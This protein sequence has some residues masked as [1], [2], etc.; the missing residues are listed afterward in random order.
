M[1]SGGPLFLE[2]NRILIGISRSTFNRVGQKPIQTFTKISY[3]FD[4][5][6]SMTGLSLP[7]FIVYEHFDFSL[8]ST[9]FTMISLFLRLLFA[10]IA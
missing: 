8:L 1:F 5:I 3:F 2:A 7:T 10:I 9:Y 4:W 6:S